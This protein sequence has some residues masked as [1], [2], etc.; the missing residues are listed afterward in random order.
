MK[1]VLNTKLVALPVALLLSPRV[2]SALDTVETFDKGATDAESYMGFDGIGRPATDRVLHGEIVVGYGIVDR[3]SAFLATGLEADQSF[4]QASPGLGF[5]IFGT[6]VETPHFDLDLIADLGA[7]GPRLSELQVTP[8]MELN[9]DLDP[10]R[11]GLG[12]YLRAGVPIYGRTSE[13]GAPAEDP[14]AP[15]DDAEA[16]TGDPDTPAV[17]VELNPGVYLGLGKRH[18]LLLEFDA[19]FHRDPGTGAGPVDVGGVGLG[20]NVTLSPRIELINQVYLDI[21]QR[22]EPVGVGV[23]VGFIGTIPGA[24]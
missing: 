23:M 12:L 15:A 14:E 8:A 13:D 18:E 24:R 2:A 7:S 5:G 20:Y 22:D 4:S 6:P 16:H 3:F 17:S 19:A 10:D 21:P 11:R 9:L 1:M